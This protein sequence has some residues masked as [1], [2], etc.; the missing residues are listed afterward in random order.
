M[1][2]IHMS[3]QKIRVP[4]QHSGFGPWLILAVI[5]AIGA[6]A[7]LA[8]QVKAEPVPEC[9]VTGVTTDNLMSSERAEFMMLFEHG[10]QFDETDMQ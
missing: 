4:R 9:S 8:A 2:R 3:D 6:G 10:E 7:M 1:S 5:M